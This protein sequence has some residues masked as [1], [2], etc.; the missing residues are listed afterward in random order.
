MVHFSNFRGFQ[1]TAWLEDSPCWRLDHT[2]QSRK[3]PMAGRRCAG[4]SWL[5]RHWRDIWTF[6]RRLKFMFFST[7]R[8]AKN[9]WVSWSWVKI[10]KTNHRNQIMEFV[11]GFFNSPATWKKNVVKLDHFP[12]FHYHQ[13][14]WMPPRKSHA[15]LTEQ[16]SSD[17]AWLTYVCIGNISGDMWLRFATVGWLGKN[18]KH[19]PQ[20]VV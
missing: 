18:R 5:T 16:S 3:W 9:G 2:W 11:G 13:L 12:N 4:N 14:N 19:I 7:L 17:K 6:R 8:P 10:R 20:M 15:G 1:N